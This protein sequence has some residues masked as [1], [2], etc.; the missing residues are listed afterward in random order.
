MWQQ[1]Q[2][3][4]LIERRSLSVAV[5]AVVVDVGVSFALSDSSMMCWRFCCRERANR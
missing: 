5:A 4:R 2:Q 1:Q 3:Q